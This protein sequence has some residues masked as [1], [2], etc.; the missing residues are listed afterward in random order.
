M[1]YLHPNFSLTQH[2]IA[3]FLQKLLQLS[4]QEIYIRD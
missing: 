3:Q 2:T 4:I 1:S